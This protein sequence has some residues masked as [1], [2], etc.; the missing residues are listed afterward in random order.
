MEEIHPGSFVG[1]SVEEF[2]KLPVWGK[3]L[4]GVIGIVVLYIGYK[5]FTNRASSA[6]SASGT[7]GSTA[8]GASGTQTPF[9]SVGSGNS[10]VPLL[11]SNVSPVYDQSGGLTAFQQAAPATT[12]LFAT[13]RN[14]VSSGGTST[15]DTA[16][17]EGIP[18]RSSPGGAVTGDIGYGQKVQ[19][20]GAPPVQGPSN[21]GANATNGSTQ[22]YQTANGGYVSGYD[23]ANTSSGGG[24]E[25]WKS[26]I[27]SLNKYYP[28]RGDNM[29]EVA[30]KL[31]L[32]GGWQSFN[33]D[34]F[35]H[36]KSVNIPRN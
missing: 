28:Q 33:V 10:S 21:F 34:G 13:I 1:D 29:N 19:L 25:S 22:W 12:S 26:M 24:G 17:P 15:Y 35:E 23:V 18:V 31:G 27:R 32:R 6:S 36:G 9:P 5:S 4:V 11:P 20:T 14:A 30:N 7:S 3:V 8:S 2:K 16:H